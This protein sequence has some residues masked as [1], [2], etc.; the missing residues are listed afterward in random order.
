MGKIVGIDLGTTNSV[1]A[2]LEGGQPQIIPNDQ[3]SRTTPS[4][5]AY[6]D[7]Q[8]I[9]VGDI[10]KR[11]AIIN[12]ENTFFSVKRFIGLKKKELAINLTRLPYKII[13]NSSGKIKIKC[14]ILNK[15]FSP[16]EISAQIIRKLIQDAERYLQET[17][18]QVV[19]TVPA[20]FNASQR[21]ATIDAGKIAGLEVLRIINEPTAAALAYGLEQKKH[22]KILIF[23]LGGG[24]LDVSILDTG[25]GI[26]EVLATAGDIHLGGDDFTK[27]IVSWLVNTFNEQENIDISSDPQIMQRLIIASEKAKIE[28]SDK[29]YTTI[30]LPFLI[31]G[32][33]HL[34]IKLTRKIYEL[35]NKDLIDKCRMHLKKVL[36]LSNLKKTDIYDIILVGGSTRMPIIRNL[37]EKFLKKPI[38]QFVNP[39]EIVA[40]GAALQAGIVTGELKN[41]LLV[42][43]IPLSLGVETA[44]GIMAPI[45]EKNTAIPITKSQIFST[46]PLDLKTDI[47]IGI[48]QGERQLVVDNRLLGSIILNEIAI[49]S[50]E[51][52][53][54][55][56]TFSIDRDGLLTVIAKEKETGQEQSIILKDTST[57]DQFE[58]DTILLDA[59]KNADLD[60]E[61]LQIANSNNKII[62]FIL[63]IVDS[64]EKRNFN[65]KSQNKIYR[66][67][68]QLD[69]FIVK[70]IV[71]EIEELFI[72]LCK[73]YRKINK[74]NML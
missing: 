58:L 64:L 14:P 32:P 27:N 72:K 25:D 11:Q 31:P 12:S 66:I 62:Y 5:V 59:Q 15:D 68:Q 24:T 35:L 33:K 2:T 40:L 42:D 71:N 65:K 34:E 49:N 20:H 43:I 8:R 29:E 56:I 47:H 46:L 37:L 41:F 28:L 1:I 13:E 51:A 36:K 30:S 54:I 60:K 45:I 7:K 6:T 61:K 18:D 69:L 52:P 73:E 4:I 22:K 19:L 26:F 17:I 63:E 70:N 53:E 23:D 74:S 38:N 16:E 55:T 9:L 48:Y 39:D 21:Q 3:G 50:L 57:L 44:G 67:M 10:A